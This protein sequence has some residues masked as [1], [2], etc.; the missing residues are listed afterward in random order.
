M[1][2]RFDNFRLDVTERR[3]W[4]N[5]ELIPLTPKQFD[6]LAYFVENSGRIAK[7]SD[8]LDAVWAGAYIEEATLARSVSWLRSKLEEY[9]GSESFIQTVPKLGYRFTADVTTSTDD[10]DTPPSEERFV[11][12]ILDQ[13]TAELAGGVI[14]ANQP[15]KE[16][17]GWE[18]TPLVTQNVRLRRRSL[19]T[20]APFFLVIV[21]VALAGS[22]YILTRNSPKVVSQ[23]PKA[24]TQTSVR[25]NAIITIKNIVVDAAQQATDAGINVLPGDI[26]LVGAEGLHQPDPGQTWTVAGD[27]KAKV[28]SNHTFQQADPWSLIGWIGTTEADRTNS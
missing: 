1:I 7:K 16:D 25:V 23:A 2:H 9:A 22:G 12:K 20:F 10:K 3:L 27:Q 8:L 26:I 11:Q 19:Q 21:C 24:D 28:S 18:N 17:E 4:C 14:Q 6:L 15:D 13:E 5:D